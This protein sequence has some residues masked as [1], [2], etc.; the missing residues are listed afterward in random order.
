MYACLGMHTMHKKASTLQKKKLFLNTDF[1]SSFPVKVER[2]KRR[3]LTS[4]RG[5]LIKHPYQNRA[6]LL[7]GTKTSAS[8]SHLSQ[9]SWWTDPAVKWTRRQGSINE[10][11]WLLCCCSVSLINVPFQIKWDLKTFPKGLKHRSIILASR[12]AEAGGSQA[13][14]LPGTQ[15]EFMTSLGNFERSSLKTKK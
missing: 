15:S 8:Y 10:M 7:P 4:S 13:Q 1:W 2:K 9:K 12:E 14:G 5:P 6:L 11:K 3:Q